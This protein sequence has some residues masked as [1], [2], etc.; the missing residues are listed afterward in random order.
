MGIVNKII[1]ILFRQLKFKYLFS[2][3]LVRID[4]SSVFT[5][6]ESVSIRKSKI[7]LA[8]GSKLHIDKGASINNVNL[9]V[10]GEVCIGSDSIIEK[11]ESSLPVKIYIRQKGKLVCG[12]NSRL[13]CNIIIR[14]GGNVIIGNYTNINEG[15]EIRSDEIVNIGSYN[16]ISY[17]CVIWD[18]NTHNIYDYEKRRKIAEDFFPAFGHEY[19]KPK[20]KPVFI[21]DDCWI[22][23]EAAILKGAT[24]G[25]RSIIGFRT[26]IVN[27]HIDK[28]MT[29]VNTI[30]NTIF[31]NKKESI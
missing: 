26:V 23:R 14:F 30:N 2:G 1:N 6:G 31:P 7:T 16:Q 8:P 24:V 10:D 12:N 11:G 19:E 4:K 3:S 18:T 20:V 28:D 5:I 21:G 27:C 25:D 13:R 9:F 22:G 15:T 29:V 17:N